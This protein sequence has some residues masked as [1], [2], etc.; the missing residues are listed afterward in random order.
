MHYYRF[1][2]PRLLYRVA[3]CLN[4]CVPT[5]NQM[6]RFDLGTMQPDTYSNRGLMNL[7]VMRTGVN[8]FRPPFHYCIKKSCRMQL[9]ADQFIQQMDNFSNF[10]WLG[11]VSIDALVK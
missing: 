7:Y 6:V 5:L 9:K 11:H 1:I 2:Q 10:L 8:P 4:Q 3:W